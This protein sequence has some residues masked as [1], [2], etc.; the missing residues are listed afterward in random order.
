MPIKKEDFTFDRFLRVLI[1]VL[2]SLMLIVVVHDRYVF[3]D[4]VYKEA[5]SEIIVLEQAKD[6]CC[7]SYVCR[8][9][10]DSIAK[11]Q[12]ISSSVATANNNNIRQTVNVNSDSGSLSEI[13]EDVSSLFNLMKDV[14]GLISANGITFLI[15]LIVALLIALVN[16]KIGEMQKLEGQLNKQIT[17]IEDNL[18]SRLREQIGGEI[19]KESTILY[20]HLANYAMLLAK[21]ES[22]FNLSIT[23]GSAT[24]F[25]FLPVEDRKV[26]NSLAEDVG[27]LCSRLSLLCEPIEDILDGRKGRIDYLS[28]DEK[29][30][31][32]TY[33]ADAQNALEV[34]RKTVKENQNLQY[35]YK[36]LGDNRRMLENIYE[37]IEAVE[38]SPAE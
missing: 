4:L 2:V 3:H 19:K 16:D 10:I 35:L 25:L 32:L 38:E 36:I 31:L 22:L 9:H 23:I 5:A 14:D 26:S 28:E 6:S 21:V 13:I 24:K 7:S 30:I 12:Q 17:V 33:L 37:M 27:T 20:N 34:S 15:S 1:C 18:N 8:H 29:N 11:S